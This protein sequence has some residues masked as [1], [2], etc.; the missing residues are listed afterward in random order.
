[1]SQWHHQHVTNLCA[2]SVRT[3]SSRGGETARVTDTGENVPVDLA[4][5]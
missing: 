2:I 4:L 3:L 5:T 1:M